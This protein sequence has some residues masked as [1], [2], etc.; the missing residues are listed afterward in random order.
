M[1]SPA[2]WAGPASAGGAELALRAATMAKRSKN[3]VW[4]GR[5]AD[6]GSQNASA[7]Q[8]RP[9]LRAAFLSPI[10]CVT[11]SLRAGFLFPWRERVCDR[12]LFQNQRLRTPGQAKGWWAEFDTA[13][14]KCPCCQGEPAARTLVR[15]MP[16]AATATGRE[17]RLNLGKCGLP[18]A[19]R[20][21]R[22]REATR[23]HKCH[24]ICM[25][26]LSARRPQL[27]SAS[28]C[29]S[30]VLQPGV[31]GRPATSMRSTWHALCVTSETTSCDSGL[32]LMLRGR[33]NS[34]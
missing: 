25:P 8:L 6:C 11:L 20:K 29:P 34:N 22:S 31:V 1:G 9:V 3:I 32:K 17:T 2:C 23:V 7:R 21:R 26:R 24:C 12:T 19:R 5:R 33:S 16:R 13:P 10:A 4:A 15:T 28:I 14:P 30:T 27:C 18:S